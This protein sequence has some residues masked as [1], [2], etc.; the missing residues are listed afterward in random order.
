LLARSA[1][2]PFRH[3]HAI[4]WANRARNAR[5]YGVAARER[6]CGYKNRAGTARA[7]AQ[8]APLRGD[9]NGRAFRHADRWGDYYGSAFRHVYCRGIHKDRVFRH[10]YCRG[11]RGEH[12]SPVLLARPF[13]INTQSGGQIGR[14]MRAPTGWLQGKGAAVTK[15]APVP[16]TRA[17][18]AR[19]Y[20]VIATAG[21]SGTRIVGVFIMAMYSGTYIVTA[22]SPR[23][24]AAGIYLPA[25]R[26][27]LCYAFFARAIRPFPHQQAFLLRYPPTVE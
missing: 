7:G 16:Q 5:P 14:A 11:R 27:R 6:C 13:G 25:A 9:C 3:Q 2:P 8:C 15:T 26:N 10:V 18:N 12:C 21:H 20:G 22:G 4:G 24:K 19:P 1:R 17:R 23:K